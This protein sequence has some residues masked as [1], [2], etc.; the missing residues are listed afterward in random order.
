MFFF[1]FSVILHHNLVGQGPL[2]RLQNLGG[3]IHLISPKE[4][5]QDLGGL[6]ISKVFDCVH[7]SKTSPE[8]GRV[9]AG[10]RDGKNVFFTFL[11]YR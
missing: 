2:I 4:K 6:Y 3:R 5:V 9:W 11:S 1:F 10:R 8:R 7:S